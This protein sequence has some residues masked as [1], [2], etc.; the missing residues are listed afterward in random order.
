MFCAS[1]ATRRGFTSI[2]SSANTE[3]SE[4]AVADQSEATPR[5]ESS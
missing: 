3:L 2:P 4:F 1:A 5:Y